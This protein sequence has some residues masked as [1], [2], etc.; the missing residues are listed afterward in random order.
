MYSNNSTRTKGCKMIY[1]IKIPDNQLI[2]YATLVKISKMLTNKKCDI[3]AY[4]GFYNI[5]EQKDVK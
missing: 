3:Y 2:K 4:K 5:E 1:Q